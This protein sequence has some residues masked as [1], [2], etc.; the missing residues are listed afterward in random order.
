VIAYLGVLACCIGT[1]PAEA[2]SA[3]ATAHVYLRLSGEPAV[4]A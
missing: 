4:K 3:V 1:F 2:F